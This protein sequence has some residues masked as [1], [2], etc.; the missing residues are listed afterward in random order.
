MVIA[1]RGGI[2]SGFIRLVATGLLGLTLG[3]TLGACSGADSAPP[4]DRDRVPELLVLVYDRS[5]SLLDHELEHFRDLTRQRLSELH[6]GDRIVAIELLE[7][8]L[9]EEPHRWAQD[10]PEREFPDRVMQRDSVTRARFVQ[11]ARD[12]LV[13]YTDPEGRAT[14][15]GTDI[16]STLHLVSG[17]LAA[18]PEYRPT[19]VL[20]SDMLQ[21]NDVMN[22]EGLVRMPRAGW[23]SDQARMGTLPDL[24]G[25]CI[26]VVGARMDTPASQRVRA[27]WQEYFE[28][29]GASFRGRNYQHRAVRIPEDP[30]V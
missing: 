10:V 29:T 14:I 16:L 20:F 1:N 24:G 9:E 26:I 6:H 28:A 21:A 30:C 23:V 15:G 3:L 22:M 13:Q 4:P 8:S 7:R 5:S 17:E 25:A 27:F 19:V 18:F 12:Y 2:G 11:D